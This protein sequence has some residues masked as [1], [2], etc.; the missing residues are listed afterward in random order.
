MKNDD[1]KIKYETN[2]KK[3]LAEKHLGL[4]NIAEVVGVLRAYFVNYSDN[5]KFATKELFQ[6]CS[7]IMYNETEQ[8]LRQNGFKDDTIK[9]IQ[10]QGIDTDMYQQLFSIIGEEKI[11]EIDDRQVKSQASCSLLRQRLNRIFFFLAKEF[12]VSRFYTYGRPTEQVL[13]LPD[14]EFSILVLRDV[15]DWGIYDSW[16]STNMETV[17][18]WLN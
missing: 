17:R 1:E 12:K 6:L 14:D 2:I 10:Q 11:S 15:S 3:M 13:I 18:K 9:T 16:N 7:R 5:V 4:K 8:M